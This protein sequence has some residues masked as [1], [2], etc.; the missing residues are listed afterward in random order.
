M[1][2]YTTSA[3]T[4]HIYH[5]TDPTTAVYNEG[6][7]W[8]GVLFAAYNGFAA[9][10]AFL[11]PVI[12]QKTSRKTVH[13]IALIIG[14]I[15]LASFYV[16]TDPMMLLVSMV[17]VGLA[18]ASILSMP[19]AILAGALPPKKMGVYMGI[20][21]FFIV[22]P[23]IAAAGVLGYIMHTFLNNEAINAL[24]LGGCSMILSGILALLVNDI[25][26]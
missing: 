23:Q 26:A 20:F 12:A 1:W 22:I 14:G 11:L 8:V 21:N 7:D 18:W 5:T 2:I 25:D 19:Y 6:A 9:L 24:L 4:S 10:A 17:G 13:M 3:V 16:I 15:S